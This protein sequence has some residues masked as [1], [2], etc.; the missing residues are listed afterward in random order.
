M[1]KVIDDLNERLVKKRKLVEPLEDVAWTYGI[2]TTYLN[3]IIEYWHTKYN[4][5]ER[6]TLLN[7][8]PQYMT[9]I[10]GNKFS[11]QRL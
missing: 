8:Y 10:Q 6:Q 7:K 9:N 4:W 5:S 3:D 2:S 1:N 11:C